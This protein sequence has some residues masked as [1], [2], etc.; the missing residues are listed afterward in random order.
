MVFPLCQAPPLTGLAREDLLTALLCSPPAGHLRPG[1]LTQEVFDDG[2]VV[3]PE[4]AERP[5]AR[6]AI[7]HGVGFDPAATGVS[8]EVLAGVHRGVHGAQDGAGH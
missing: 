6:V 3:L 7:R 1:L 4:V 5:P 2:L 8:E